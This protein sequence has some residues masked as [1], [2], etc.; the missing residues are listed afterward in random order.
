MGVLYDLVWAQLH[1]RYGGCHSF[2]IYWPSIDGAPPN[3]VRTGNSYDPPPGMT[4]P[5]A[6]VESRYHAEATLTIGFFLSSGCI[7]P[8]DP[9]EETLEYYERLQS[10]EYR[11]VELDWKLIWTKSYD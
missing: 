2:A 4:D 7:E 6:P 5:K 1:P 9:A 11:E 10:S 3:Y 8:D